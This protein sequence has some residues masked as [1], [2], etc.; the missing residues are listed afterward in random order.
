MIS[1]IVALVVAFGSGNGALAC[2]R[3]VTPC[4]PATSSASDAAR[5]ERACCCIEPGDEEP[6]RQA[7]AAEAPQRE[8]IDVAVAALASLEPFRRWRS[9]R[10]AYTNHS[11]IPPPVTLLQARTSFLL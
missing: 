8:R 11:T 4:C 2:P 10:V 9:P 7:D 6:M 3:A 5:F 1:V